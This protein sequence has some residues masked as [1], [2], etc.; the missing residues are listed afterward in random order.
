MGVEHHLMVISLLSWFLCLLLL[1]FVCPGSQGG[2]GSLLSS[3]GMP[4]AP[5]SALASFGHHWGCPHHLSPYCTNTGVEQAMPKGGQ[6]CVG[7]SHNQSPSPFFFALCLGGWEL[8]REFREGGA[9]AVG[10]SP[11]CTPVVAPVLLPA[12][13][14]CAEMYPA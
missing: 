1:Q 6:C 11:S 3:S 10:V 2:L 14:C 4:G 5:S 12:V 9:R 8:Q 7:S 13:L